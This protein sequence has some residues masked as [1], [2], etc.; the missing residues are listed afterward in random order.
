MKIICKIIF[1]FIILN[2]SAYSACNFKSQFGE[3]KASIEEKIGGRSFPL[4]YPGLEVFPILANDICPNEKL[5]DIV[6]EYK[7]LNDDL[8]A[9]NLVAINDEKNHV[10]EKLTLMKYTKKVYGEFDTTQNPKSYSGF[11]VFEKSNEFIVYRKSSNEDGRIDEQL[12]ISTPALDIKLMEFYSKMEMKQL[13]SSNE[14]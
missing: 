8:I 7:F 14:N 9:I 5:D 11:E 12:Y 13:E 1:L 6:I 10:S 3:S 2:S 4:E